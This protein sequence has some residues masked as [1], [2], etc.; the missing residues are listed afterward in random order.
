MKRALFTVL[1]VCAS[2]DAPVNAPK[3]VCDLP[4]T[5]A[6]WSGTEVRWKG[7]VVGAIPHGYS[8]AAEDCQRRGIKLDWRPN[9]VGG[10]QLDKALLHHAF[11]PGFVR[12]E[13]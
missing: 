5:L 12:H 9:A 6:S 10:A 11:K 8:L 1:L 3:S 7:V 13:V 4:R 2:C